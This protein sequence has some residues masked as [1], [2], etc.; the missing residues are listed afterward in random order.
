M[1]WGEQ[2]DSKTVVTA[3]VARIEVRREHPSARTITSATA[4]HRPTVTAVREARVI[5]TPRLRVASDGL[6]PFGFMLGL[7]T[8]G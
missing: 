2:Y 4:S 7:T 3:T 8:T 5:A 6:E 1:S